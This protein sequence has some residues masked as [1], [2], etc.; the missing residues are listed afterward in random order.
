LKPLQDLYEEVTG[1]A[2]PEGGEKPYAPLP[3]GID[4]RICVEQGLR[5]LGM[6]MG[7]MQP[8]R[9]PQPPWPAPVNVAETA[10]GWDVEIWAP[11]LDRKTLKVRHRPGWILF[12]GARP[13]RDTAQSIAAHE[14]PVTG[15]RR[16]IPVPADVLEDSLKADYSDG[17]LHIRME[18]S[19]EEAPK[20][21]EVR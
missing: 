12:E 8:A 9:S 19:P 2:M 11:G 10:T 21:I 14:M 4:P 3:P 18:K 5:H 6:I 7:S 1:Q 17:V 13:S 20:Q 16:E 15:F